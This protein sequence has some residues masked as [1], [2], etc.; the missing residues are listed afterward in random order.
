MVLD[1]IK[2]GM[3]KSCYNILVFN[4]LEKGSTEKPSNRYTLFVNRYTLFV[5]IN[6]ACKCLF[7]CTRNVVVGITGI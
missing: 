5:Y 6:M 1:V 2:T 4:V 3:R 7:E